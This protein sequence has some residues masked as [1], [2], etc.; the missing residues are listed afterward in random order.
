MPNAIE[1]GS[2]AASRELL[3]GLPLWLM[4]R[5]D[6]ATASWDL[7]WW[8]LYE[9]SHESKPSSVGFTGDR[10]YHE[11]L[12]LWG[13]PFVPLRTLSNLWEKHC[14]WAEANAKAGDKRIPP[15]HVSSLMGD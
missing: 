2:G 14:R 5:W 1:A 6:P 13:I 3:E 8:D 7:E 9:G 15:I 10:I 11:R 12:S 4:P